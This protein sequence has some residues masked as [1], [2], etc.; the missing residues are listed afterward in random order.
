MAR[1][2]E[3]HDLTVGFIGHGR[4]ARSLAGAFSRRGHTI[5]I[6]ARSASA[7][8][9]AVEL[10][11]EEA[12]AADILASADATVLAVP[13]AA[14]APLAR[15]LAADAAPGDGRLVVHLAGSLPASVLAPLAERGYAIAAVHPLQVL[16][17]WR[18]APGTAFAVDADERSAPLASRLV[19]ELGGVEFAVPASGRTAYHAAA[20]LAANLGMTL[21]AEAVDLMAA[22]GIP[23]EEAMQG[24]GALVRGGLEAAMDQGL[25]ASLT[26]PVGRGDTATVAGHLDALAGDPELRRAYAAGSLLTL[27]QV[28]RQG[29][30]AA[31]P[32][33]VELRALLEGAL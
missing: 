33:A 16:S 1:L 12:S 25:P 27:R 5:V 28:L 3:A 15:D 4:A 22:Q 13:D 10:G 20:S 11:A 24:L 21:L 2:P 26:G 31:A 17:G 7:A 6:A 19:G 9:L 8:T 30:P 18:V 23:R 32:A 14:V 29:R